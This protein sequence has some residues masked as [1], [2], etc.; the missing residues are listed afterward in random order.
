MVTFNERLTA[1]GGYGTR[2]V[3]VYEGG[4]WN[5]QTIPPIGRHYDAYY[6]RYYDAS[7]Y[8]DYDVYFYDHLHASGYGFTSLVIQSQLYVFGN[9][10]F[11]SQG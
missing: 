4:S 1:I 9:I 8:S 5:D 10:P 2:K 3:E 6:D 11:I 7:Y